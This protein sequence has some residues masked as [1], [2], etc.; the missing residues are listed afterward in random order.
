MVPVD[1]GSGSEV[2]AGTEADVGTGTS[3][4]RRD[5]R[6]LTLALCLGEGRGLGRVNSLA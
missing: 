4:S 3:E 6:K 2:V 5:G 1:G